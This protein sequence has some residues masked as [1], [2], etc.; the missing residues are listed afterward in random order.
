MRE[1]AKLPTVYNVTPGGEFTLECPIRPTYE[2]IT[3]KLTNITNA[4]LT[5]LEI[6][7]DGRPIQRFKDAARVAAL[8]NYYK[9][10]VTAGYVDFHFSR[11]EMATVFEQRLTALGTADIK[12]LTIVGKIDAA[13]VSPAVEAFAIRSQPQPIGLITKI[14]EYPMS[15][16]VS[17]QVDIDKIPLS[18][19]ALAAIHLFKADVS[20]CTVESNNAKIYERPKAAGEHDQGGRNRTPQTATCTHLDW[21]LEGSIREALDTTGIQDFRLR[22]TIDTSGSVDVVVEYLDGVG[23]L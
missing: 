19:A 4:Q 14:R 2:K 17:G 11:P 6:R 12:T 13:C 5:A 18:R 9:R 22:P 1:H 15:F 8:N 21:M 7:V 3:L 16:A 23:G 10:G 20:A